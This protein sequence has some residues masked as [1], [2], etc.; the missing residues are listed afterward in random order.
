M[1]TTTTTKIDKLAS[2]LEDVE[3]KLSTADDKTA[4]KLTAQRDKLILAMV[5]AGAG[6]TQIARTAAYRRA[7]TAA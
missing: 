4:P 5:E 6:Y 7:R 2:Q 3:S 1:T